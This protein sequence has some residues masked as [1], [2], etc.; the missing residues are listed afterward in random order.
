MTSN[1]DILQTHWR[2]N[3]NIR[4][5]LTPVWIFSFQNLEL[6]SVSIDLHQLAQRQTGPLTR[7]LIGD[8]QPNRR[9]VGLRRAVPYIEEVGTA[10]HV[11]R[12]TAATVPHCPNPNPI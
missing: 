2:L 5:V 10:A 6:D 8:A 11:T 12:F 1:L 3:F 9:L 7:V 4:Y